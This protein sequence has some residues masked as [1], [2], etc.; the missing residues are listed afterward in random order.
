MLSTTRWTGRTTTSARPPAERRLTASTA[1]TCRPWPASTV[2]W[3]RN[4]RRSGSWRPTGAGSAGRATAAAP[5]AAILELRASRLESVD[6]HPGVTSKPFNVR[7]TRPK[8]KGHTEPFPARWCRCARCSSSP[9]L[10]P[11]VAGRHCR[12]PR[13]GPAARR[14][15]PCA[16]RGTAPD[17]LGR[18]AGHG[19]G[20]HP[21]RRRAVRWGWRAVRRAHPRWDGDR[22][23]PSRQR[24]PLASRQDRH[25][26]CRGGCP[27]GAR[28][29][30]VSEPRQNL[31]VNAIS[32]SPRR[33]T[34]AGTRGQ[35]T[36]HARQAAQGGGGLLVPCPTSKGASA[37]C[38]AL[39]SGS[40]SARTTR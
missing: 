27:L 14:R 12:P 28:S 7:C 24:Q 6:P 23:Q 36:F 39:R 35:W 26:R 9:R 30:L 22:G 40:P 17:H 38:C 13:P 25:H 11:A 10:H 33:G 32:R 18:A 37:R 5:A 34:A 3:C 29:P 15:R 4:G 8:C 19:A 16:G 2:A 1:S 31:V 21:R 20:Q